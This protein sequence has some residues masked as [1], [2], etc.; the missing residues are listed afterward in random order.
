[1]R[2]PSSV[3]IFNH[4]RLVFLDLLLLLVCLALDVRFMTSIC[5]AALVLLVLVD[6]DRHAGIRQCLNDGYFLSLLFLFLL[7]L[8][9]L[10]YTGDRPREWDEITK[11]AGMFAIPFFFCSSRGITGRDMRRI[12]LAFSIALSLA[13]LYCLASAAIRYQQTHDAS[14]F[15][16]HQLVRSRPLFHHAIFFSFFLFYAIV[17]WLEEAGTE[18]LKM[19]YRGAL[20]GML[21]FFLFMII[22]LSSKLVIIVTM[23][24][25]LFFAGRTFY[26]RKAKR[27]VPIAIVFFLSAVAVLSLTDNIVK[28]RFND[29]T[30]GDANLFRQEK[31]ST[32]TYFNGLQ[33]RLLTWRFTYEI[34]NRKKAWLLGVSPGDAQH[35]LDTRY[36]ETNMYLG[37][38]SRRDTGFLGFNCHNVYLQ[39]LL[40]SGIAG[41]LALLAA[42]V[43]FFFRVV[44]RKRYRVLFYF[45]PLLAFG[46]AESVLS[47]Q[48]AIL[49]FVLFPL[50]LEA[51]V[52]E[53]EQVRVNKAL[54]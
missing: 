42:I 47:T 39:T 8:A 34:L 2:S 18:A 7:Q 20:I 28:R 43:F 37:E 49:L 44:R 53:E 27:I 1:M 13:C 11:K 50:L 38:A 5:T 17:Y 16:Y 35:E 45:I 15:F 21:L 6:P 40:E 36:R 41:L 9:G 3:K 26:F 29:I 22:L 52:P 25:L 33:F 14:V 30:T 51:V 23:L 19:R 48:Y 54:G 46:L 12:M 4:Q 24:Y 10:L 31:F 32:D